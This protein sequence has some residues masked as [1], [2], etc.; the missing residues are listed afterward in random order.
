MIYYQTEGDGPAVLFIH[1]GVADSRMWQAQ[2]GL[3]GLQTIAF[4]QR[5]FGQ[6]AWAPE[7]YA[8]REDALAVLDHLDIG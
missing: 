8:N 3:P 6:T 4:D 2:M 7:P 1:A 5:G